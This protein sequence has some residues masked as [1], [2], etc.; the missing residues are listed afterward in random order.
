MD[1]TAFGKPVFASYFEKL[2][3]A[4]IAHP[5]ILAK[6]LIKAYGVL[7]HDVEPIR[8]LVRRTVGRCVCS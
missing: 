2:L 5:T 1:T 8:Q 4:W 3:E 6:R 7:L